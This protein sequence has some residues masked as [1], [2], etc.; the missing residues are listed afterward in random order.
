MKH[1]F[2]DVSNDK[3]SELIDKWVKG[4]RNRAILKRRLIDLRTYDELSEEFFLSNRQLI[5][6]VGRAEER[7]F[8]VLNK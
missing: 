5:R 4:D 3:L 2:M 6:I 1:E 8:R 7:L